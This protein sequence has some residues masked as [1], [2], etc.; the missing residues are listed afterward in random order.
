MPAGRSWWE[1]LPGVR[2]G[3]FLLGEVLPTAVLL[4]L[5][6]A[7]GV[8]GRAGLVSGPV[9]VVAAALIVSVT[10]LLWRRR[11]PLAVLGTVVGCLSVPL[12]LW[13]ATYSMA[14]VWA[15]AVA[16]FACGAHERRPLAYLAIPVGMAF[17]L[18][19]GSRDPSSS[20]ADTWAWSLNVILVFALGA[21]LRHQ[22]ALTRRAHEADA[23]REAAESAERRLRLARDVH[24]V[25]A[26]SLS[27]IVV[28]AEAADEVIA[29]RP[30]QARRA[31]GRIQ[32]TGRSSLA[33]VR[34]LVDA[35][36]EDAPTAR[37]T[38]SG[39][40]GL[41]DVPA[42]VESF[43]QS[44]LPVSLVV[45]ARADDVPA[46]VAET[47]YRVVQESLTN[48]LRHAGRVAT[49]VEVRTDDD[50]LHVLV[51]DEGRAP[52]GSTPGHGLRGMRERVEGAGGQVLAGSRDEG[53]YAVEAT[54]PVRSGA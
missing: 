45:Q 7:E 11:Y 17:L 10:V 41:A 16:V 28:Q 35:L 31:L 37:A 13:G 53:G 4:P 26:H 42:L 14:A 48:T 44:G 9:P 12:L 29:A 15:L 33:E 2:V 52:A 30:D 49:L 24:D 27:I 25:L 46:P 3:P 6:L 36:R 40:P 8:G 19:G 34:S 54:L 43:R 1:R 47:A 51:R 50:G 18:L 39:T 32:E 21:L 38:A 23:A 22:A 5:A 20:L